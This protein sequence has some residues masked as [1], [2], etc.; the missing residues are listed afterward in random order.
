MKFLI[1]ITPAGGLSFVSDGYSGSTSDQKKKYIKSGIMDK[2]KR[3]GILL[4]DRGFN[5]QDLLACRDVRV[6][7]PAFLRGKSHLSPAER[8]QSRA[9]TR[10]RIHLERMIGL[11]KIY[12]FLTRQ[13]DAAYVGTSSFR[14]I[15][16][17][18]SSL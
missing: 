10:D 16:F 12:P 11:I 18:V 8:T 13:I 17:C 5:V 14:Y 1:G 15:P 3:G 4:A 7:T 9:I 6:I 2:L